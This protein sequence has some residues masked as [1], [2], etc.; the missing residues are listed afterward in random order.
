M[1]VNSEFEVVTDNSHRIRHFLA[2]ERTIEPGDMGE[3]LNGGE[4]LNYRGREYDIL[5]NGSLVHPDVELPTGLVMGPGVMLGFGVTFELAVRP[6]DSQNGDAAALEPVVIGPGARVDQ[7]SR[8]FPGVQIGDHTIVIGSHLASGAQL[9]RFVRVG[10]DCYIG[11]GTVLE[12]FVKLDKESQLGAG[13]RICWAARLGY[14]TVTGAGVTVGERCLVG[15][16]TGAVLT[17]R[18]K[19]G[20]YI[21][22]HRT[23]PPRTRVTDD[24]LTDRPS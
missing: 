3:H 5:P 17:D 12:D 9:E 4:R 19:K 2:G 23:V 15:K 6:G 22:D 13:T 8:I 11:S 24:V 18:E 14:K 1:G 20:I 10:G 16:A 7:P 21:A